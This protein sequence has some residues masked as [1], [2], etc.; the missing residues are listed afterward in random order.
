MRNREETWE[1]FISSISGALNREIDNSYLSLEEE[2][3]NRYDENA[4]MVVCRGEFF[5]TVGYVGKEYAV[6]IKELLASC[7]FYRVDMVDETQVGQ[8]EIDL[9]M[10]WK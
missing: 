2:P 4:V 3:D 1:G 7:K 10:T 8:R 9:V 6:R 5:G